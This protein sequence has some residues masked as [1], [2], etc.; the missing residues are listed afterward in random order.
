MSERGKWQGMLTIA[1]LNWPWYAGAAGAL[2]I[3]LLALSQFRSPPLKL[4][5]GAVMAGAAWFLAGSLGVAHLVYDRSGLYRSEWLL[6]ALRGIDCRKLIF[7]HSGF[8]DLSQELKK[9]FSDANWVILD[10]YDPGFL[11]EASIRRARRL[12]PPARDTIPAGFDR[13]PC[14][15]GCADAVLGLLAIHELRDESQ[16]SCWFA[17]ARRS[18]RAD[19]RVVLAEHLRDPANFL[20]FGP[21]FLH[22]HSRAN[23]EQ[24]WQSAGLQAIDEFSITPWVRVFVLRA[25]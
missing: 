13:W 16:R 5:C 17:E 9:S 3:A 8:D 23:W 10:H 6:R 22:F 20:A 25:A 12:F 18:L 4:L 15:S 1:R 7:C 11:T 19:G 14:E 24:A 21:G 2:I